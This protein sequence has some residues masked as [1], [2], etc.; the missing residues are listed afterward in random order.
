MTQKST[1]DTDRDVG[2]RIMAL[3]KAKGLSQSA[4]GEALGVT[5]QQIQKYEKGI[6][7]V[8][9]SRLQEIARLLDVPVSTLFGDQSEEGQG[10]VLGLLAEN[11]AVDLLRAYIAIEDP[12]M[13]RN[14]LSIARTAV[15]LAAG[16]VAGRA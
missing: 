16:P 8:G 9:A 5:F 15:R 3:R 4:L 7:R 14:I 12:E 6:N 1:T 10:E 13:R 11:G 2:V